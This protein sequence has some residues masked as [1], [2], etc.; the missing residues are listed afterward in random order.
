MSIQAV[1]KATPAVWPVF[2]SLSLTSLTWPV[3]H[4]ATSSFPLG[5]VPWGGG[6]GQ[7]A[8]AWLFGAPW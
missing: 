4:A 8:G 1:E 5:R 3:T 2:S 6:T 7:M